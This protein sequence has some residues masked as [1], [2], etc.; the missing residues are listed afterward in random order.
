M[1][2]F[3]EDEEPDSAPVKPDETQHDAATGQPDHAFLSASG[4][5]T[6]L[7]CTPAPR[8]VESLNLV[9]VGESPYAVEGSYAHAVAETSLMLNAGMLS[10]DQYRTTIAHI[11]QQMRLDPL[12]QQIGVE[13]GTEM[14]DYVRIYVRHVLELFRADQHA[15]FIEE[16]LDLSNWVPGS[17]GTADALLVPNSYSDSTTLHVIDLKYGKGVP[18][19]AMNNSQLRLYALGALARLSAEERARVQM[20]RMHI[21]QPRLDNI[22]IEEV[23]VTSLLAWGSQFVRPRAKMADAGEGEFAP[24]ESACRWCLGRPYCKAYNDFHVEQIASDFGFEISEPESTLPAANMLDP[25]DLALAYSRSAEIQKWL[26]TVEAAVRERLANG[27]EVPGYKMIAGRAGQRRWSDEKAALVTLAR[28]GV[29]V[30]E[31]TSPR[32][33]MSVSQVE[34]VVGKKALRDM[35][36]PITQAQT[37]PRIAREDDPSPSLRD[38]IGEDFA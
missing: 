22:S 10:P 19:S 24:S 38:S 23:S 14:A 4:S 18:V 15:L 5:H 30:S 26:V 11:A 28:A 9:K 21:V 8:F 33:L 12:M 3:T 16:R 17:F 32:Q 6:W 35:D 1:D 34:K 27:D 36:L 20:V 37:A 29:D 31:V 7:H 13:F 25:E 2:L